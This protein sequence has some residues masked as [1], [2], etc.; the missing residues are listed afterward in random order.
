MDRAYISRRVSPLKLPYLHFFLC[1]QY[2]TFLFQA[3]GS[4]HWTGRL[5]PL[6][7]SS[8]SWCWVVRRMPNAGRWGIPIVAAQDICTDGC[9]SNWY[10]FDW[11]PKFHAYSTS[12]Y[13]LYT[14]LINMNRPYSTCRL[15]TLG[16]FQLLNFLI[17]NVSSYVS[18]ASCSVMM[19]CLQLGVSVCNLTFC[20][21][22]H[23]INP[24]QVIASDCFL[25]VR[26]GV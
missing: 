23:T 21:N 10:L 3:T 14:L 12:S 1:I 16:H 2:P 17:K 5:L 7:M 8:L 13:F 4:R 20:C 15:H 26:Q 6:F 25:L 18:R 11:C 22:M 19:I 24:R 9:H